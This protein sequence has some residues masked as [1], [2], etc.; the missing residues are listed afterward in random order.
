MITKRERIAYR[1]AGHAAMALID[2]LGLRRASIEP[3]P[4]VLTD[5]RLTVPS[6]TPHRVARFYIAG[7]CA[8]LHFAPKGSKLLN[9]EHDFAR[10]RE[11]LHGRNHWFF[12]LPEVSAVV[13][14]NWTLVARIATALLERGTLSGRELER[15]R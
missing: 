9:S 15:L 11:S 6:S 5:M 3:D 10:A 2:G 12:M 7:F 13:A 4:V 8:E 1:E 14:S